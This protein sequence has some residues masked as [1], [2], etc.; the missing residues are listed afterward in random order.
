M[1]L[2]ADYVTRPREWIASILAREPR[3][4]SAA[5]I[6]QG[7]ERDGARVSL[8]DVYKRQATRCSR[9]REAA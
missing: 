1:G 3:F 4:L 5:Q 7:L 2:R 6:H 8:S 9:L